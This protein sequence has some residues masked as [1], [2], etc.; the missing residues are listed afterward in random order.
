MNTK[1]P[2]RSVGGFWQLL[3]LLLLYHATANVYAVDINPGTNAPTWLDYWPFTDTNTWEDYY[4][5]NPVSYT[6]LAASDLGDGTALVVDTN[7]PAWLQ[8]HVYE[9]GGYTNLTVN[10]GTVELWFAPDWSSTNEGGTGPGQ[11][12]RLIEAGTYTTNNTSGWWSL[13]T[14]PGGNNLYFSTQTNGLAATNYLSVPVAWTTNRWHLIDLVYSSTNTSLY[15]D[16]TLATNGPGLAVWP[17]SDVLSNGFYI[18]S[19]STGIAQA[20]GMFDDIFT[21]D[22][23]LD[24]GT[25]AGDFGSYGII[26]YLNPENLANVSSEPYNPSTIPG[27]YDAITGIGGLQEVGTVSAVSSTNIWLTNVVATV[28]GSGTNMT[29]DLT[30]TIQG[31]SN[32]VPYDVFANSVLSFGPTGVPWAWMGQGEHGTTY[33]LTGLPGTTCFLILGTPLDSDG[34]GLTDAYEQLVSKTDPNNPDTDG[35]G[36]PDSWEVLL[37]LNPLVNDNAQET[38]R[39]NYGYT[40]ADWLDSLSGVRGGTV[41]MDNEGNVLTVSQ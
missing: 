34:D 33:K 18:G 5:D 30:F 38:T 17:G 10:E 12:G 11:W 24:A 3:M 23:P 9:T 40:S 37:G 13:Y 14:D 21:Y 28:V 6:N 7:V 39:S 26:F 16:G 25:I 22:Y 29:T 20:H 27:V 19:D 32:D 35:D 41:T 31:G 36:I 15:L 4:G 8:Y 1:K 2:V